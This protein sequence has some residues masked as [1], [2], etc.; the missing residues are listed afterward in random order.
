[1]RACIAPQKLTVALCIFQRL[2]SVRGWV[3]YVRFRSG[4]CVCIVGGAGWGEIRDSRLEEFSAYQQFWCLAEGTA[5]FLAGLRCL[6]GE[7]YVLCF[8]VWE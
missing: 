8:A 3:N 6:E 5:H 7:N 2:V 4:S 1:M